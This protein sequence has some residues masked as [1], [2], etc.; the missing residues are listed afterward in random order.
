[1]YTICFYFISSS[2]S[3]LY[4]SFHLYSTSISTLSPL[5][6]LSTLSVLLHLPLLSP[7]TASSILSYLSL[8]S[9]LLYL[10]SSALSL[11]YFSPVTLNY[12]SCLPITEHYLRFLHVREH[13]K[14]TQLTVLAPLTR[15]K[16]SLPV[17][18]FSSLSKSP[19]IC[20]LVS[21]PP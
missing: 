12:S 9:R 21:L 20:P 3:V 11:L 5:V 19:V 4:L 7:L 2:I 13:L 16:I 14:A 15:D 6:S 8:S 18:L 1:M 10:L 17:F